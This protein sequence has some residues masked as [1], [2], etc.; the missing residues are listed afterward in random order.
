M[1][2]FFV[3][4]LVYGVQDSLVSTGG[5]TIGVALAGFERTH[6]LTTGIIL[7]IV[8]SLSMAYGSFI[9]E[10]NF[11]AR[12]GMKHEP[13]NVLKY[14]AVM[15]A[16]YMIAGGISLAPFFFDVDHAVVWACAVTLTAL[17][18]L[19]YWFQRRAKKAAALTAIGAVILGISV[20]AGDAMK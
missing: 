9:A 6:I 1:D 13:K 11:M 3:R 4:N 18:A 5:V 2:P 14:A 10:D 12:A 16:S 20:L 7:V 19:L 8:E 17:F 15:F